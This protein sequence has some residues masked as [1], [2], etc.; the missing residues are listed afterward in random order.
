MKTLLAILIGAL[1]LTQSV[2]DEKKAERIKMLD[3]SFTL[4][5]EKIGDP[6]WLDD[7]SFMS[8]KELMYSDS[9]LWLDD[10]EFMHTFNQAKKELPFTH[11]NIYKK[12]TSSKN[13]DNSTPKERKPLVS[14]EAIDAQTAYLKIDSWMVPGSEIEK[15]LQKIGLDQYENLIIDLR[16]N[17]G[18]HLEGPIAIAQFLSQEPLDGG[19]Y[20]T[21]KLVW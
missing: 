14:W 18:G 1:F 19:Y 10:K 5:E 3:G 13:S 7:E 15:A 16:N 4:L 11:F 12:R 21:R 17:G 2:N 6:E 20:L 9:V 8:L